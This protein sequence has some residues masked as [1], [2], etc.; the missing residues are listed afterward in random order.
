[1]IRLKVM[2]L[3]HNQIDRLP[4]RNLFLHFDD[5]AAFEI[6]FITCAWQN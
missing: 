3:E 1:M 2:H 5:N 4:G 6:S